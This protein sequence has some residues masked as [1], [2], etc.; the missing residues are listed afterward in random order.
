VSKSL[1][2]VRILKITSPILLLI[3]TGTLW[4]CMP[5][6]AD[7]TGEPTPDVTAT[8][9]AGPTAEPV[10]VEGTWK[11]LTIDG[12]DWSSWNDVYALAGGIGSYTADGT[13]TGDGFTYTVSGN[14]VTLNGAFEEY[15]SDGQYTVSIDG[16][17]MTWDHTFASTY[18]FGKQ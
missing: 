16:N 11:V 15:L 7:E 10:D 3:L 2:E 14:T 5:V 4:T 12:T 17:S 6:P 13:P 1:C 9:T 8:P 18:V